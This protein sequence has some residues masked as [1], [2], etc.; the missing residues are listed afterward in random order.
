MSDYLHVSNLMSP[1]DKVDQ[2]FLN[3]LED[4][5]IGPPLPTPTKN[6]AQMIKDG[7]FGVY[8]TVEAI[9][10][11]QVVKLSGFTVRALSQVRLG[12]L[13]QPLEKPTQ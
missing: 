13:P 4:Y 5:R 10:K 6:A 11:P 2:A 7:V 3:I 9:S 1:I 12:D 8:T